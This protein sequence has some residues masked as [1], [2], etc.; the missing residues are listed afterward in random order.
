MVE[1][2]GEELQFHFAP[3]LRVMVCD[4]DPSGAC[5][6]PNVP[7]LS[8]GRIRRPEA[9]GGERLELPDHDEARPFPSTA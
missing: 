7:S 9:S 8:G 4:A 5:R 1:H 2:D 6:P 3:L